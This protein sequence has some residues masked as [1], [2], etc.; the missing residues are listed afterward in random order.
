[1]IFN[2]ETQ[3]HRGKYMGYDKYNLSVSLCL[4]AY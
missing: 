4:R 2:T 3:S 1:M